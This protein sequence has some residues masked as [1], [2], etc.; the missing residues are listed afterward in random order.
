MS[1]SRK[2]DEKTGAFIAKEM[3]VLMNQNSPWLESFCG[4]SS[5]VNFIVFR[6]SALKF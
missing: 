1:L 2:I 5:L 3:P 4:T 6:P